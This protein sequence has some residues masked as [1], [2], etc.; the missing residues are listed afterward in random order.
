MVMT[1]VEFDA[2]LAVAQKRGVE[3]FSIG[4]LAVK[5]APKAGPPLREKREPA[6]PKTAVDIALDGPEL[7]ANAAADRILW[8]EGYEPTVQTTT[9]PGV[10]W[11]DEDPTPPRKDE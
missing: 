2:F 7:P 11:A 6:P 4:E 3:E 5:F 8:P 9:G 1:A 10:Q